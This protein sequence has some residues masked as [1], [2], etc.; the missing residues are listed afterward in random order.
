[1]WRGEIR[2]THSF[3]SSLVRRLGLPKTL[4]NSLRCQNLVEFYPQVPW[5]RLTLVAC[6]L[7][8]HSAGTFGN[9]MSSHALRT[10]IESCGRGWRLGFLPHL[11]KDSWILGSPAFQALSFSLPEEADPHLLPSPDS[12]P[13][14]SICPPSLTPSGYIT[15]PFPVPASFTWPHS[16]LRDSSGAGPP[17]PFTHRSLNRAVYTLPHHLHGWRE[18][19]HGELYLAL[20]NRFTFPSLAF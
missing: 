13:P 7:L 14:V 19:W 11:V 6:Y 16:T 1:M 17:R 20:G 5:R 9:L 3:H 15:I 18:Q 12:S 8:G 2:E 4:E 10:I